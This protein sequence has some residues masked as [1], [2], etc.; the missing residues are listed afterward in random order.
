MGNITR[1]TGDDGLVVVGELANEVVGDGTKTLDVLAGGTLGSGK[2]KGFWYIT[3]VIA[4]SPAFGPLEPGD[5]F[6][7]DG[8]LVPKVG[9]K[10]R[11]FPDY[12]VTGEPVKS[13]SLDFK[14]KETD[15][16]G[17]GDENSVFVMGKTDISGQ[18]SVIEDATRNFFS[19]RFMDNIKVSGS[20]F[21][22][23]KKNEAPFWVIL[24]QQSE[25]A[26]GETVV[27]IVAKV[28]AGSYK[29][30]AQ[31]GGAQEFTVDIKPSPGEKVRRVEVVL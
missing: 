26:A 29:A 10:C 13:W 24:F 18:L 7:N 16:T 14:K 27:A 25:F 11:L 30:G 4:S 8:S 1:L 12:R 15:V 6:Y 9:E 22:K 21:T 17:L 3:A 19:N 23:A 5:A 2:G 31:V 28:E 20:T